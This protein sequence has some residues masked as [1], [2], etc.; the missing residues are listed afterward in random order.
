VRVLLTGVTGFVGSRVARV[1]VDAGCDV[2]ALVR[3]GASRDR[4][5]DLGGRLATIEGDLAS[6]A[7]AGVL[8]R[9]APEVCIH[10][11]WY[12]E[13]GRYLH[14]VNENLLSFRASL[15]LVEALA[16]AG[17]QRL[18][19]AGTCA[20]YGSPA[21]DKPLDEL[22]P[23]S[24][25]TPY[26]RAKSALYLTAQDLAAQVGMDLAWARLFFLYGPWEHPARIVPSAALACLRREM[27]SATAGEQVRD[28]LHVADAAAALWTLAASD[29]V[30]P[31]NV[32]SGEAVTLRS[33]LEAVEAAAGSQGT[34]RYGEMAYGPNEWMWMCGDNAKVRDLGW[35]PMF[36]LEAGI[37]D[38]V[39]WW[40]RSG[41]AAVAQTLFPR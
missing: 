6:I 22:T 2:H 8:G 26:A 11:A 5:A 32:C 36:G 3:P 28:Y 34:I 31:V 33:V 19:V 7:D 15:A 18:V 1:L 40:R 39:E 27:L 16:A 23:L 13:P 21:G 10:L 41:E 9:V 38:T 25:S 4:I 35:R 30:G 20:E 37:A 29:A 17:C 12:A 14:A 24:P